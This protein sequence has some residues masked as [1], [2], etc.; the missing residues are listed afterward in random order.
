MRRTCVLLLLI[1]VLAAMPLSLG[2]DDPEKSG[3][4]RENV[5]TEMKKNYD[6]T[7]GHLSG[8]MKPEEP[9]EPEPCA[10]PSFNAPLSLIGLFGTII[11]LNWRR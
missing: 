6:G 2:K 10:T 8:N 9:Y 3:D 7:N 1:F 11:I 5:S 4:L